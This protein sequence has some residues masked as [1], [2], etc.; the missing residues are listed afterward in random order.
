M[1]DV[2]IPDNGNCYKDNNYNNNNQKTTTTNKK[3]NNLN[4]GYQH[5]FYKFCSDFSLSVPYSPT[6][7]QSL[8]ICS[9]VS[10]Y[11]LK[12]PFFCLFVILYVLQSVSAF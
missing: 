8:L 7:L 12:L 4:M 9:L 2:T 10:V 1:I 11:V 5:T 6:F 3:S